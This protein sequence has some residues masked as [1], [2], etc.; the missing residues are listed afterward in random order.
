MRLVTFQLST[1]LGP[2]TRTGALVGHDHVVDLCLAR[3]AYHAARGRPRYRALAEAEVPSDMLELLHG[4]EYTMEAAREAVDHAAVGGD[5]AVDGAPVR[6]AVDDVRILAPLPRP[7]SLRDFLVFEEH[8]RN[9]GRTI[10]RAD[11]LPP[12]WYNLPAHYKGNVEAI[13]GPED[14]VP[15]PGYTEKL[16][17]ELEICAVVG[18]TG[19]QVKEADGESYIAGYTLYNDWSARDIQMREGSVGIGPGIGKDFASSIG[20]CIATPDEFS[21]EDSKLEARI[22]GETWSSGTLANMHFS[23]PQ[24]IE[25]ISQEATIVP[26]DLLGSGTIGLGCGFEVDRYLSPGMTVELEAEGIGLLRNSIG[27]KGP[28]SSIG[29]PATLGR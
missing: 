11:Q 21:V 4:G 25:Y 22:D 13:Y 29:A 23:F 28:R 14:V 18:K 26:G 7:N 17:Y 27:E 16:D 6:H 19:R 12:E 8:L 10:G 2:T 1:P 15:Y 3:A 20:P 5:E 9:V 24:I